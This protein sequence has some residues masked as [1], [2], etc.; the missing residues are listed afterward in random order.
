MTKLSNQHA[1]EAITQHTV[2]DW[3]TGTVLFNHSR[4]GRQKHVIRSR[5]ANSSVHSRTRIY[6][7]N[8]AFLSWTVFLSILPFHIRNEFLG[9]IALSRSG[10]DAGKGLLHMG[11]DDWHERMTDRWEVT[12]HIECVEVENTR[13]RTTGRKKYDWGN[14]SG[15]LWT[16]H[17]YRFRDTYIRNAGRV[18]LAKTSSATW[19]IWSPVSLA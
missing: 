16:K 11:R 12:L 4:Q 14:G 15:R 9:S 17:R 8:T 13:W 18:Y 3:L 19:R 6:S 10:R 1:Q 2:R 7:C 5:K